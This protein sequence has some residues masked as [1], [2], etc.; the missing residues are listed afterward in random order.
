MAKKYRTFEKLL[1]L[2]CKYIIIKRKFELVYN[3]MAKN[4]IIDDKNY[5]SRVSIGKLIEKSE[6]RM[7][8]RGLLTIY[9]ELSLTELCAKI[10]RSKSTVHPHLQL[11]IEYN[12]VQVTREKKVRGNIPAKYYSLTPN[13]HELLEFAG[14]DISGGI[15]E[16]LADSIIKS[17]KN[18][19]KYHKTLLEMHIKFFNKLAKSGDAAKILREMKYYTEGYTGTT[20]YLTEDQLKRWRK[21]YFDLSIDFYKQVI[22][23]NK[24]NPNTEKP[25]YF[26]A[27]ILPLKKIY[28][29]F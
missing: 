27:K 17:G 16:Q 3:I 22:K 9:N 29:E 2:V 5:D 1:Y 7:K 10:G 25:Y 13:A 14:V 8:I 23:E 19:N 6:I 26:F 20:F 18:F 28:E 15:D 4:K 24:E 11:L 12:I 21:L